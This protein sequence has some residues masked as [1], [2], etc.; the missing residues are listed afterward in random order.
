MFGFIIDLS[1]AT[2]LILSKVLI[3]PVLLYGAEAWTLL[4]TDAAAFMPTIGSLFAKLRNT[5]AEHWEK[6]ML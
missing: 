3:L 6:S 2:K 5:C 4:S 1:R